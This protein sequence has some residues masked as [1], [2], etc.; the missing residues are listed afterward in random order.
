M[1]KARSIARA[2]RPVVQIQQ[3]WRSMVRSIVRRPGKSSRAIGLPT[4]PGAARSSSSQVQPE[5]HGPSSTGRAAADRQ[6]ASCSAASTQR[7]V[8]VAGLVALTNQLNAMAC[9]QVY[10]CTSSSNTAAQDSSNAG[11]CALPASSQPTARPR[12]RSARVMALSKCVW[13]G[14]PDSPYRYIGTAQHRAVVVLSTASTSAGAAAPSVGP[15]VRWA[16]GARPD[17]QRHSRSC[18]VYTPAPSERSAAKTG[19]REGCGITGDR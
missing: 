10:R 5:R 8:P 11:G 19:M 3:C 16:M 12:S 6:A 17:V 1:G 15:A 4:V 7:G 9:A 18:V 13:L 2:A 14:Q